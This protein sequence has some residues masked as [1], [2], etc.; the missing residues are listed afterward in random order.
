MG[1][2]KK[3]PI[4]DAGGN[5]WT[6][7]ITGNYTV[8]IPKGFQINFDDFKWDSHDKYYKHSD[9]IKPEVPAGCSHDWVNVG[10]HFDKFICRS[11]NKDK[12]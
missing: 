1:D 10:F 4:W 3:D 8:Q 12:T 6:A 5:P 2:N 11:C 7:P 9:L